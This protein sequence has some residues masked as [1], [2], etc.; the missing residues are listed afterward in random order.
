MKL[1]QTIWHMAGR[2]CPCACGGEGFL[3][4]IVCPQCRSIALVCDEHGT[5]FP[6]PRN[7]HEPPGLSWV[8]DDHRCPRCQTTQLASFA[9]ATST[10]I[11]VI[12][13]VAG[14]YE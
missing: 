9:Y 5:V 10:E 14:E 4:F 12:G 1:G 13:F 2:R 6:D 7:V 11:Q 3:D 8:E